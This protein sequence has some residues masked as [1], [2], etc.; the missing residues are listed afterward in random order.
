M[1]ITLYA[2]NLSWVLVYLAK[3][4]STEQCSV[5]SDSIIYNDP[6]QHD[7][8]QRIAFEQGRH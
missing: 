1:I 3:S 4:D 8:N 7:M 5:N 6:V 2:V